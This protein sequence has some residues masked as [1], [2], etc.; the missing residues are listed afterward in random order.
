[1]FR[2]RERRGNQDG[3]YLGEARQETCVEREGQH[4]RRQEAD[5]R[6]SREKPTKKEKKRKQSSPTSSSSLSSSTTQVATANSQRMEKET[7][8][9][10]QRE[11]VKEEVDSPDTVQEILQQGQ[12]RREDAITR[13]RL[14]SKRRP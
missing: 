12:P 5:K 8:K 4:R 7:K 3:S 9:T 2:L 6:Y 11:E 14:E 10:Q 1:M 13:T